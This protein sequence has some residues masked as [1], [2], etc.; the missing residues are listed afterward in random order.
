MTVR[1]DVGDP[2]VSVV[3][4]YLNTQQFLDEAIASVLSQSEAN[5][6]LLLVDD[7]STDERVPESAWIGLPATGGFDASNTLIGRIE[8]W[9]RR[10]RSEFGRRA[11]SG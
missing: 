2:T 4:I 10:G 1:S 6:E 8:G 11:G 7:G 3:M 5:L 9:Q